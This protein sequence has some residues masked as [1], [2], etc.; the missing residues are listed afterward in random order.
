MRSWELEDVEIAAQNN[1]GTFFIPSKEERN[2][3]KK[4]DLVRLHFLLKEPRGDEPRAERMW[5]E[6]IKSKS[7]LGK[8]IGVLTNQPEFIRDLNAGDEIEFYSKHIA[9]VIVEKDDPRWIDSYERMA[10]VSKMCLDKDSVIRFL[11]R[12]KP[13]REQDSGWRMFTGYE[14][15]EYNNDPQNIRIINVGWLLDKD[16]TLLEPLKCEYG[17]VFERLDK[18]QPWARIEDWEPQE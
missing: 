12:E 8:Y 18:G 17:S 3:K 10:I 16:S 15:D 1:L 7:L 13:D 2:S 11:Y 14:S 6:I 4:G 5:V 9:R